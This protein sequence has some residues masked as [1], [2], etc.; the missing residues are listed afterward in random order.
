MSND[1]IE[2]ITLEECAVSFTNKLD[3]SAIFA[4]LTAQHLLTEDDK[5]ELMNKSRTPREK[6]KYIM[7]ILPR[8]AGGW[9][10]KLLQCLRE[11]ADGT[12]H[13]DLLKEL[14]S[15]RQ[16]LRER[17]RN[18]STPITKKFTIS[19]SGGSQD[20]QTPVGNRL[21]DVRRR[22][23]SQQE[24]VRRRGQEE[25]RQLNYKMCSCHF[26]IDIFICLSAFTISCTRD[27]NFFI[28]RIQ[29]NW[30]SN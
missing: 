15:K 24:V 22:S 29:C 16:E 30:Y 17:R 5:Q 20:P 23:R 13:E 7:H 27:T 21:E 26:K 10:D 2:F 14:E 28:H 6:A 1:S 11:S 25:V 9:F 19:E 18:S 12:G 4:H 8:K 3:A